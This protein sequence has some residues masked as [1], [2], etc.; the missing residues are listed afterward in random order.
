[1]IIFN[2]YFDYYQKK[3]KLLVKGIFLPPNIELSIKLP[4][5]LSKLLHYP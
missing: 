4:I 1:M 2:H 3:K 5:I